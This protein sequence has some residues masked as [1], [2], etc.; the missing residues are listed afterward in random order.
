MIPKWYNTWVLRIFLDIFFEKIFLKIF[1]KY[2]W[3]KYLQKIFPI[4]KCYTILESWDRMQSN[5]F[6]RK[7]IWGDLK[8]NVFQIPCIF[9]NE[10]RPWWVFFFKKNPMTNKIKKFL[11]TLEHL[12]PDGYDEIPTFALY[13]PLL[14]LRFFANIIKSCFLS[15]Y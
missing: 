1:E 9:K 10:N 13:H 5:G 8:K 12:I 6:D 7:M 4:P 2:F 3:K 14:T 15:I 11:Y